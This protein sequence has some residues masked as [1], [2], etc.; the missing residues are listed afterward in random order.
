[1]PVFMIIA[2]QFL[3][4]TEPI[5]MLVGKQVNSPQHFQDPDAEHGKH[6]SSSRMLPDFLL[7]FLGLLPIHR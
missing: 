2:I 4:G 1:M 6:K 7:E 5:E 3:R